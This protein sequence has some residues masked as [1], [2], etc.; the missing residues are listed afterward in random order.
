MTFGI[1]GD[2]YGGNGSITPYTQVQG[3]AFDFA[4]GVPAPVSQRKNSEDMA[5]DFF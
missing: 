4:T 1:F 5:L 3:Q 2:F